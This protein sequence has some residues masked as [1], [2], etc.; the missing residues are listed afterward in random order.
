MTNPPVGGIT[1]G[2]TDPLS[3]GSVSP[4]GDSFRPEDGRQVV[5][6]AAHGHSLDAGS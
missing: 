6:A 5:A 3:H 2:I 1:Q 4:W